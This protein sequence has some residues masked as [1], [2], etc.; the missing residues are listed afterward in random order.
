[1]RDI[2]KAKLIERG[3]LDWVAEECELLTAVRWPTPASPEEAALTVKGARALDA[4]G[5]AIF[6]ELYVW[7]ERTA[8]ALD[9][10][11]FRVLGNEA[12]I[13]M[14][15]KPPAD[16]AEL[17]AVRGVG[18]DLA[19]RK[20]S[21]LL[22]AIRRGQQVPDALLPRFPR[23]FRHRPDPAFD[24]RMERLKALRAVLA[25][26]E[27]LAPGVLSPNWLLEGVA[28]AVPKNEVELLQVEGIRRWQV[29]VIGAEILEVVAAK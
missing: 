29:K 20:G 21:E 27:D 17:S 2:L 28:R 25:A 10:A 26:R 11:A 7:R 19:E 9:R 4:R 14:A 5:L 6:R 23:G 18:R 16:Q 3:R 22:D 15:G 24:S 13:A 8:D 12:M 1:L